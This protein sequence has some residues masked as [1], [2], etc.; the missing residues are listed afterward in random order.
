M[1]AIARHL[2]GVASARANTVVREY[3]KH[4][5]ERV[6]RNNP[7]EVLGLTSSLKNE[8][9]HIADWLTASIANSEPWLDKVDE[10]GRPK[11]LMKFSNLAQVTKEADKA[12]L[13][14]AQKSASVKI[15]EGDE[16]LLR[17]LTEGF[18]VV[19]LLTDR[20]LDKE[21]AEM[22]HCIGNGAYDVHL[23][24]PKHLFLS[25]RDAYGNPH[26]TLEVKNGKVAQIQGKQNRP[27]KK[28]YIRQIIELIDAEK[29]K[30]LVNSCRL[31]FVM[32]A[33]GVRHD[34]DDLPDGLTISGHLNLDEVDIHRLP[35]NMSV[36][37]D[38]KL[39]RLPNLKALPRGLKVKGSIDIGRC[40]IGHLPE[41]L[42]FGGNLFL[43]QTNVKALPLNLHIKGMLAVI[44]ESSFSLQ[45]GI[46]IDGDIKFSNVEHVRVHDGIKAQ[47]RFS[48][49]RCKDFVFPKDATFHKTCTI[50]YV[51]CEQ[52]PLVIPKGS[53][54]CESLCFADTLVKELPSNLKV[55]Q[56]LVLIDTQLTS[57]PEN[58]SVGGHLV[59]SEYREKVLTH[60]SSGLNVRG[61]AG[62]GP[63]A[64]AA[65]GDN[66]TIGG[67]FDIRATKIDKLPSKLKVGRKLD[68]RDTQVTELPEDIEVG[69]NLLI[70]GTGIKEIPQG[71]LIN[72]KIISDASAKPSDCQFIRPVAAQ[73]RSS[74]W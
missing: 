55:G 10:L 38:L 45:K 46:Q 28:Q 40:D 73:L 7:P 8:I 17:E 39:Y 14:A 42:S 5:V 71:A 62:I 26:A 12:M 1:N 31:G 43:T 72:G 70:S 41:D 6:V 13:K 19:Q 36:D 3:L 63:S 11:K 29:Y 69:E 15:A 47:G 74:V 21:S 54:F 53:V 23:D 27:P 64:V 61:N 37:G 44:M 57:L 9:E 33:Q 25:L 18:Y 35:D 16:K 67:D 50:E 48:V 52:A 2:D 32:D 30:L 49:I 34:I 60:I 59:A 65:I 51:A 20:A 22:Q 58:L 68:I 56:N 4:S 24:D 66:V